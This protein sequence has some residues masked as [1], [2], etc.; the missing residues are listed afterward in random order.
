MARRFRSKK[1]GGRR[2]KS[3]AVLPVA[4]LA[5][6]V[7]R[8][9]TSG[10][11]PAGMIEGFVRD[12]TGYDKGAGKFN[13]DKAMPFWLGTGAAIIAHKVANKTGVNNYVRKMTFGYLSL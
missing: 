13:I 11:S 10:A 12:T 6:V 3:I 8:T 7:G 4:P 5:I 2:A 9:V 1:R